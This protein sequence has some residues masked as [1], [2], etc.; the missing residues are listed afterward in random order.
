MYLCIYIYVR[1]Y[2]L[3]DSFFFRFQ[4]R[5]AKLENRNLTEYPVAQADE[6]EP[7]L[8]RNPI[9]LF[10]VGLKRLCGL[11]RVHGGASD[12]DPS[13]YKHDDSLSPPSTGTSR[14]NPET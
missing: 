6:R 5:E 14:V 8:E 12:T 9:G 11:T 2:I 3:R 7:K 13:L 4:D 10:F 1:I